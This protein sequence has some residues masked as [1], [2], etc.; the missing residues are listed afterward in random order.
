MTPRA[1][2]ATIG[3]YY[4][5]DNVDEEFFLT[6]LDHILTPEEGKERVENGLPEVDMGRIALGV[7]PRDELLG[8]ERLG[9]VILIPRRREVG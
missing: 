5:E 7:D 8:R 1:A 4:W 9:H 6:I 3:R 2:L